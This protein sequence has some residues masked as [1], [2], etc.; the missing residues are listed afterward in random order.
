MSVRLMTLKETHHHLLC[1]ITEVT[2]G[3]PTRAGEKAIGEKWDRGQE[4]WGAALIPEESSLF[5]A[6]FKA[7]RALNASRTSH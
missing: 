2:S 1:L 3:T 4:P 7:R 5:P 6:V